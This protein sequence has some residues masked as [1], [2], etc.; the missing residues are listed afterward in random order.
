MHTEIYCT[1]LESLDKIKAIRAIH[2]AYLHL[3]AVRFTAGNFE[4]CP[5]ELALCDCLKDAGHPGFAK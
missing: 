4:G 5:T 1:S 3:R 2:Q